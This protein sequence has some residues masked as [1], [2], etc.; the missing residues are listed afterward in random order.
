MLK[1]FAKFP[2]NFANISQSLLNF[3]LSFAL[4]F[5]NFF[6]YFFEFLKITVVIIKIFKK[7]C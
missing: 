2:Q 1:A 3:S 6:N 5:K 7:I 4:T